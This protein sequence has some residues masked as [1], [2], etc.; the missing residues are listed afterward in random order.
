MQL[1]A[2][3]A[4]SELAESIQ[5]AITPVFLLSGV[6]VF[7]GVLNTRLTRVIDRT[8]VL[9]ARRG[10]PEET[11]RTEL[12]VLFDRRYWINRAI[13]LCTFCALLV[14]FVVAAMFLGAVVH[15]RVAMLVAFL[16]I[17]AML[18]LIVGLLAFLREVHLGVRYFQRDV[19]PRQ[20]GPEVA[21]RQGSGPVRD[22]REV[23]S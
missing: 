2:D 22:P 8:R 14:C 11:D 23:E 10:A 21:F 9:E 4:L 7:L 5:L 12:T 1:P 17:G 20:S 18:A 13:T 16:F 19:Y 15:V 3:A 6:A